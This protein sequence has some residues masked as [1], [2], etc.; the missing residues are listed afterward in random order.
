MDDSSQSAERFVKKREP[1]IFSKC[2][3]ICKETGTKDLSKSAERF[4]WKRE[5]RI[6]SKCRKIFMETVTKDFLKK[7]RKI[8]MET[9]TKI[10]QK[11]QK[12][13]YGNE[14][15]QFAELLSRNEIQFNFV[16]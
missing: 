10:F 12:D 5:P 11:V 3:K 14:N 1:R 15:Q 6:F 4:L 9:L 13:L 8:C 7:C 16:C 2:R